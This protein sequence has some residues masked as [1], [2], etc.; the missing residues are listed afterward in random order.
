MDKQLNTIEKQLLNYWLSTNVI[1]EYPL[2]ELFVMIG[3][4]STTNNK[5]EN[6]SDLIDY[7]EAKYAIPVLSININAWLKENKHNSFIYNI[8]K[9]LSSYI[10]RFEL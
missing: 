9:Q 7:I 5:C 3:K 1:E 6:L 4:L 10:E 2:F 8:Y